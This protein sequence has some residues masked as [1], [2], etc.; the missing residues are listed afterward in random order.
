MLCLA[1]NLAWAITNLPAYSA[2]TT[3]LDHPRRE[4]ERILQRYVRTNADTVFG[5]E[6]SFASIYSLDDYRRRV[7][8]RNYDE[9][10][11]YIDRIMC[12]ESNVLAREPVRRLAT[13]SGST[14]AAKYIPYT[15]S[16]QQEFNRAIGPWIFNLFR[17]E[18]DLMNGPAYWSISP[19]ITSPTH[20]SKIPGGFEQDS[21][22]L[23]GARKRLV[24]SVMAVPGSLRECHSFI[25]HR[26]LT[27]RFLLARRDL[28]LISV[29]HPSFLELLLSVADEHWQRLVDDTRAGTITSP[30]PIDDSLLAKLKQHLR[31]NPSRAAELS[32]LDP[33]KWSG[34]WPDLRLISGWAS[35]HA[36]GPANSLRRHFPLVRFEPKGLIATE[37]M[38]TIPFAD[39]WP[40]AIRSHVFEFIDEK[41]KTRFCDE[42][43]MGKEYSVVV[44]TAGGLYRYALGDRVRLD[45]FVGRTPSLQFVGRADQVVDR[46]GEK[47]NEGFVA[48]LLD[49]L[50]AGAANPFAMLAPDGE[51]YTLYLETT[52]LPRGDLAHDLD[53]RLRANPH[54]ALCRDLGQLH[55]AKVFLITGNAHAIFLESQSIRRRLGDIKPTIL[56]AEDGWSARF[57]GHYLTEPV[58]RSDFSSLASAHS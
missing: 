9:L 19:A 46:F 14:R 38:V 39:Q 53:Q 45:G 2:F 13:S 12:G 48:H 1:A 18:P 29:W 31:P 24:D 21:E 32:R 5:R 56:S 55:R 50:F 20:D 26:Y 7:P 42:L 34:F 58:Q 37:A 47:L 15:A 36:R 43:S 30:G 3:A 10:S 4:Q 28:R 11:G 35:A 44:T 41:G 17:H 49:E 27:L 23:G 33:R 57:P 8:V 25:T 54:Y 52:R 40:L 51:C 16:L 6:H 22:Y